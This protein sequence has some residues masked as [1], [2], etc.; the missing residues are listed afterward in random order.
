[1]SPP[2]S[3]LVWLKVC[4]FKSSIKRTLGSLVSHSETFSEKHI[5]QPWKPTWTTW[6]SCCSVSQVCTHQWYSVCSAVQT[7]GEKLLGMFS[8]IMPISVA[9][10]TFGGINGYLFTSSRWDP[11]L[12]L[13]LHSPMLPYCGCWWAVWCFCLQVVFLRS[14]RGSPAQPAGHDPL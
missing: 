6:S 14:Q 9:L 2:P 5:N 1:M 4:S 8:V 13:L 11:L 12:C 10:S 7:F 3:P